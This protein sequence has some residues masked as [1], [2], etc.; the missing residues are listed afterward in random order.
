MYIWDVPFSKDCMKSNYKTELGK[1]VQKHKSELPTS[2]SEDAVPV[3]FSTLESTPGYLNSVAKN[4][5]GKTALIPIAEGKRSFK[6][7]MIHLLNFEG[8][9]YT[10]TYAAFLMNN[11]KVYSIHAERD[12]DRLGL[13]SDFKL[14][15][16]LTAFSFERRKYLSFLKS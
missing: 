13:F 16:L 12:F 9:N 14:D 11:P 3:I 6:E 7:T 2:F 5:S 4:F 10:T 15:E 8:L 1:L